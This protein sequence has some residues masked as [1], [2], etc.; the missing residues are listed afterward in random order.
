MLRTLTTRRMLPV[1]LLAAGALLLAGCGSDDKPEAKDSTSSDPSASSSPSAIA[2][3]DGDGCADFTSG[4]ASD[5]VK[6]TGAFGK[7]QTA[8]F[9]EPLSTDKLERTILDEGDGAKT[10]KG[11]EVNT[12]IS[13]F[14]GSDGTA[15]GTQPLPITVGDASQ[16]GA[17]AAGVDCVPLKS[18]V[19]VVVPAKD[20]YGEEG[21]EQAGIE[22]SDSIVIVTDVLGK[23]VPL[24]PTAWTARTPAVTF[25]AGGNPTLKLPAGQPSPRLELKVLK[26]GT[27]DVVAK[28]DQVTLDYLGMS[29]NTKKIF[30]KSYGRG[31]ATFGTEQVVPGFGAALVGQKVG[32][33]LVVTIPPQYAYGEKGAGSGNELEGQTLVFVIEIKDTAKA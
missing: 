21:N 31:A 8:T 24:K 9:E 23:K 16:I 29:W 3:E 11:D 5:S 26:P 4:D 30:D 17:F 18:R 19:V 28:G 20:L 13:A 6:V 7:T 10:A 2:D 25:D 22:G 14:K 32:T 1:A 33:R 15:L 12:L 27:G